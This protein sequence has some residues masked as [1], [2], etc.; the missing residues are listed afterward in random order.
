MK[1]KV[2][3]RDVALQKLGNQLVGTWK[4]SGEATGTVRYGWLEKNLFLA[5]EFDLFVFERQVKG[6]EII[7]RLRQP[8]KGPSREIWSRAYIFSA[9]Q[10]YDYVYEL[11][12]RRFTIWFG[13]VGSSNKFKGLFATDGNSY[14]GAWSC[15]GGGYQLTAKRI[16]TQSKSW[17]LHQRRRR[18]AATEK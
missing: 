18:S 11:D 4:I 16:S 17:T 15:P 7:G 10:T 1:S 6:I 13:K 9:G 8:E 14:A 3:K 12:R 2:I 5:Q